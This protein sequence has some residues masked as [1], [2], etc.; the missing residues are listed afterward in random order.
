VEMWRYGD[1][2]IWGCEDVGD[3]EMWK[4]GIFIFPP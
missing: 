1:V 2:E 3:V 4:W